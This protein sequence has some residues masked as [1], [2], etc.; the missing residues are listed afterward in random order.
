MNFLFVFNSQNV[1]GVMSWDLFSYSNTGEP[2]QIVR[3][4]VEEVVT[5]LHYLANEASK[6]PLDGKPDLSEEMMELA[7]LSKGEQQ[8]YEE[9]LHQKMHEEKK[10]LWQSLVSGALNMF[11]DKKDGSPSRKSR[12][13]GRDTPESR[14]SVPAQIGTQPNYE[15]MVPQPNGSLSVFYRMEVLL[16]LKRA[17]A[18]YGRTALC[19]SGGAMMG[20]FLC[21]AEQRNGL[22]LFYSHGMPSGLY[23]AGLYH[24]GHVLG[25]LEAGVLPHIIS[26][27]SGGSVIGAILC[28]R[29]DDEIRRDL[30]PEILIQKLTCFDRP[31]GE[32]I[33]SLARNGCLF[34]F[35][36]WLEKIRWCVFF[37]VH[38][39]F[40]Y[41]S[42]DFSSTCSLCF[43]LAFCRLRFTCGDMTFAEA[44]R[45]TGRIFCVTLSSTTK[46]APPV[47]INYLTAPDVTIA[48]AVIASAAVPGFVPP[49]RLQYSE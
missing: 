39:T 5:S 21:F 44:Y 34:S 6:V 32:R 20:M 35:E 19:L 4:F 47:L 12:N 43:S 37:T 31:W 10:K 15:T 40:Q 22:V 9:I 24:F 11:G 29:T 27:T 14:D 2:K 17:R 48:S 8:E 41:W 18:A 49:V 33:K 42:D 3:E 46:K 23:L 26:G 13:S 7:S 38:N 36:I 30:N 28:T 25:L 16:F 1:G 45:K